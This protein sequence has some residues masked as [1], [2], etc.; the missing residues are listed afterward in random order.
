MAQAKRA[1]T[2]RLNCVADPAVKQALA[3][4]KEGMTCRADLQRYWPAPGKSTSSI[5]KLLDRMEAHGLVAR[6]PQ[7][8]C[9][10][11]DYE[12]TQAGQ[13][14]RADGPCPGCPHVLQK[15]AGCATSCS[16]LA[17][18]RKAW[19]AALQKARDAQARAQELEAE[20]DSILGG[21]PQ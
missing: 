16:A 5:R 2:V 8:M 20:L 3:M 1:R 17:D 21:G 6:K 18:M 7:L 19:Q 11:V 14:G 9:G 4:I 15:E 10:S 12:L 13:E